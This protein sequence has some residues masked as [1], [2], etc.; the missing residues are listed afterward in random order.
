MELSKPC[1]LIEETDAFVAYEFRM[2]FLYLLYGILLTI[3]VGYFFT[4]QNPIRCGYIQIPREF[5]GCNRLRHRVHAACTEF[6]VVF[7]LADR[8]FPAPATAALSPFGLSDR[9]GGGLS[10]CVFGEF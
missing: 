4:Q 5:G 10:A 1:H 9:I 7:V 2:G 8:F 3:G 6:R